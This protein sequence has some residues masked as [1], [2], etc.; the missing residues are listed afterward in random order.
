MLVELLGTG[1]AAGCPKIGCRC[2]ACTDALKGTR[3]RRTRFSILVRTEEGAMLIDTGP[4][5][6]EQLIRANVPKVD[7][8]IWTHAH[9]DHYGGLPELFRVQT[10]VR[11]YGTVEMRELVERLFPFM[12]IR[13]TQLTPYEPFELMGVRITPVLVHHPPLS[14]PCGFVMEEDACKLVITGDSSIHI[15]EK[16]LEHMKD[17]D[18]LIANA[19]HPRLSFNKHMNAA[20]AMELSK[21]VN[22]RRLILTHLSHMYPPHE[23]ASKY[24]PLAYDGM[25]IMIEDGEVIVEGESVQSQ[26]NSYP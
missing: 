5:L 12:H 11:C 21:R 25:Q 14:E 20:E 4:D 26:L 3:S 22:A 6:K 24:Y 9:Y 16:S 17:A 1:D 8:V 19:I 15:P 13:F 18:V 7:A 2:P 23:K 10:G